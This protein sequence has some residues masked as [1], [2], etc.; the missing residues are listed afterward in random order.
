LEF[1]ASLHFNDKKLAGSFEYASEFTLASANEFTPELR[2]TPIAGR[3]ILT[4]SEFARFSLMAHRV[5]YADL[6]LN[7]NETS[8]IA[9]RGGPLDGCTGTQFLERKG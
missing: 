5:L 7:E 2:F 4:I 9:P 6:N 1:G 3:K 8:H